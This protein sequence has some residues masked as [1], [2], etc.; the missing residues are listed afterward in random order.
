MNM[1]FDV[2]I[3]F[4]LIFSFPMPGVDRSSV[5]AAI[6]LGLIIVFNRRLRGRFIRALYT[7]KFVRFCL[8]GCGIFIGYG[9]LWPTILQTNDMELMRVF[10]LKLL[11][12]VLLLVLYLHLKARHGVYGTLR[13]IYITFVLQS[14]IQL[15]GYCSESFLSVIRTIGP[16]SENSEDLYGGQLSRGFALCGVRFFGLS[17]PYSFV[18]AAYLYVFGGKFKWTDV[19]WLCVYVAGGTFSARSFFIGLLACLVVITLSRGGAS[20]YFKMSAGA[21]FLI[22]FVMGIMP[23]SLAE[24]TQNQLFPWMFEFWYN[25]Q[26]TGTFRTN[27]SD[28]VLYLHHFE[29]PAST[30]AFGDG[31]M[32]EPWAADTGFY[33]P[34]LGTDAGYMRTLGFGGIPYLLAVAFFHACMLWPIAKMPRAG[35][36]WVFWVLV[37]L[38]LVMQIKG[39]ILGALTMFTYDLFFLG[40]CLEGIAAH[41]RD[42]RR[43]APAFIPGP[44]LPLPPGFA[45]PRFR[46]L[47]PPPPMPLPPPGALQPRPLS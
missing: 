33:Y 25:F 9:M 34:Y 15:G 39:D 7:D 35:A 3:T 30:I 37:G 46:P 47:P 10:R 23:E 17:V 42:R 40:L 13:I 11:F 18:L 5:P 28:A 8:I 6:I 1:G 32:L 41:E 27:S 16:I 12:M 29:L 36:K 19:F 22:F 24:K 2:I 20:L 43:K 21:M 38:M 44:P 4:M 45:P 31:Y 14:I 26:S